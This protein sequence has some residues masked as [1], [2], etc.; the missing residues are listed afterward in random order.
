MNPARVAA[1]ALTI[2]LSVLAALGAAA[3]E[4]A[5]TV[6]YRS[7]TAVYLEG[8]RA[9]GLRVGDTLEVRDGKDVVAVIEVAFVAERSASCKVVR[10]ARPVKAGDRAFHAAAPPVQV[11]APAAA[12][13]P[14]PAAGAAQATT[15]PVAATPP[16]AVPRAARSTTFHGALA[17]GYYQIADDSPADL[18]FQQTSLR[19]DLRVQ[20]LGGRPFTLY[21]RFR[22]REDR[23]ARELSAFVPESQRDDRL[24]QLSLLRQAEGGRLAVEVGRMAPSWFVGLGVLDGAQVRYRFSGRLEAGAFGGRRA[25]VGG[26]GFEA[27]EGAKFGGL[28]RVVPGASGAADVTLGYVEETADGASFR[29]TVSLESRLAHGRRLVLFERA[30]LDLATGERS[31]AQLTNL[32]LAA[33]WRASERVR[34]RLGYDGRRRAPEAPLPGTLPVAVVEALRQGLRGSLDYTATSGFGASAGATM[35]D[36]GDEEPAISFAGGLRHARLFGRRLSASLDGA[37]FENAWTRGS[38]AGL[39]LGA[40][41]GRT[42]FS[43]AGG[44]TSYTLEADDSSRRN[45]YVGASAA[46]TARRGFFALGDFAY[47]SGDDIRGPRLRLEAGWRF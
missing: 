17:L 24:Y 36:K 23:R 5:F 10:A 4:R 35:A 20:D 42:T 1:R 13:A 22:A 44:F 26:F 12:A 11:D 33:S 40:E 3:S 9:D 18:D 19:G 14:T 6:R 32:S 30:E 43:L 21:S 2:A 38:Q 37:T 25:D 15:E 46:F 31:D 34:L 27:A 28:L 45:S 7:E 29:R 39:R 8:G 16:L 47:D 41:R